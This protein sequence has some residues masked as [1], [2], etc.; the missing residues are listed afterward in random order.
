V[1]DEVA[2][3]A[4]TQHIKESPKWGDNGKTV[5]ATPAPDG[6]VK[7]VGEPRVGTDSG[8]DRHEEAEDRSETPVERPD[9]VE[10]QTK[11]TD[12]V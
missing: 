8:R 7:T 9:D 12:W 6:E 3:D 5:D 10:G 11:I 1:D 4:T 2:I